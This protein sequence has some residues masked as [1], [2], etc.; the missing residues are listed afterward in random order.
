MRTLPELVC[1]PFVVL[2]MVFRELGRRQLWRHAAGHG[3][4]RSVL[5][6]VWVVPSNVCDFGKLWALRS[7]SERIGSAEGSD[8][9]RG[10]LDGL[11]PAEFGADWAA[12]GRFRQTSGRTRLRSSV[13]WAELAHLYMTFGGLDQIRSDFV[14][15]QA[16]RARPRLSWAPPTSDHGFRAMRARPNFGFARPSPAGEAGR[17][18]CDAVSAQF[19][20]SWQTRGDD[21]MGAEG[22]PRQEVRRLTTG[23]RRPGLAHPHFDPRC[24][25]VLQL[26]PL[27]HRAA[28]Q[29]DHR[30]L[31][32]HPA[33]CAWGRHLPHHRQAM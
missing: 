22:G 20:T 26:V 10:N 11:V 8:H 25:K 12:R 9:G 28:E 32:A 14:G 30:H 2:G 3:M 18:S 4:P 15:N 21:N 27:P 16:G 23:L 19:S 13:G 1:Y 17:A 31:G 29:A 33:R 24:S 5:V 6:S 7:D